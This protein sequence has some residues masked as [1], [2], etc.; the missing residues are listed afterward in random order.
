MS[1]NAKKLSHIFKSQKR[2]LYIQKMKNFKIFIF[3]V[4]L[5]SPTLENSS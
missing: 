4:F 1:K 3:Q 5:Q 2:F